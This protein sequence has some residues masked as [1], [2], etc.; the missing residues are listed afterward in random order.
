[1]VLERDC[2]GEQSCD[3]TRV[4]ASVGIAV[5]GE[6]PCLSPTVVASLN[7]KPIK[8]KRAGGK[9]VGE[10]GL[11]PK[12]D[13]CRCNDA[14]FSAELTRDLDEDLTFAL[15][16]QNRNEEVR[17]PAP[18][19]FLRLEFPDGNP[20]PE[21]GKVLAFFAKKNNAQL[22]ATLQLTGA[23]GQTIERILNDPLESGAES[24]VWTIPKSASQP[25]RYS[26]TV[27][28][29]SEERG[30]SGGGPDCALVVLM[31]TTF[32]VEID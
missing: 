31:S 32:D 26:V 6:G 18:A 22:E 20:V 17:W 14:W 28:W 13:H 29:E 15:P 25:G 5:E 16:D 8:P 9:Q 21:G 7:G 10:E 2:G 4:T 30:C 1:M 23:S 19:D 27:R 24:Q 11:F 12:V 3:L